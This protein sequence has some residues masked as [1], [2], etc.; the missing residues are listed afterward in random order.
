MLTHLTAIVSYPNLTLKRLIRIMEKFILLSACLFT[1]ANCGDNSTTTTNAA[2]PLSSNGHNALVLV[3]PE[4]VG[5]NC[6]YAGQKIETGLDKNDNGTLEQTEVTNTSYVCNG[7]NSATIYDASAL[8][9]D[10]PAG[11]GDCNGLAGIKVEITIN[12][13]KNIFYVCGD[14]LNDPF[15]DI[16]T[17]PQGQNCPFG[18]QKIRFGLTLIGSSTPEL[19]NTTYACSILI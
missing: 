10:F 6:D 19:T 5:T 12:L 14:A 1:L 9:T 8:H 11:S 4:A 18:G 7:N 2:I 13:D 16:T 3:S 15:V 17:E